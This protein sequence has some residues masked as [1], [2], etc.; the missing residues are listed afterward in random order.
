M[1]RI[2][3]A[4]HQ[5]DT[6]IE[7]ERFKGWDPHDALNSPLLKRATVGNRL[8]GIAW[9]QLLK[10]SPINPRPWLAVPK[11]HNPKGMGLFLASYLRKYETSG[12]PRHLAQARLFAD[13]LQQHVS[14]GYSGACWGYNFDWPNRGFFAPAG[15]PTVV[16]TAF[17]AQA[18]LDA[19]HVAH[20]LRALVRG[21]HRPDPDPLSVARSACEFLLNDLNHIRPRQDELCFS[22]TPLDR[23][24]VY[25]ANLLAAGLLAEVYAHTR[26]THLA[27]HSLAA[28]RHT[29]RRQRPDGSWTYGEGRAYGW[30]DNFHTGFV[31]IGLKRVAA[32]LQSSEFDHSIH[33]GYSFWKERLFLPDGTPK[34]YP[35]GVYPIDVHAVA[36]AIMT[37][38]AFADQ[39][40]GARDWAR[41]LAHWGIEHMQD[42]AG[43][44]HYQVHRHYRIRIPYMR[45]SQAWMQRALTEL[46][47]AR[48]TPP[49]ELSAI[50]ASSVREESGG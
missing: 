12:D 18:F 26:E 32:R 5:L 2:Q 39:D 49:T 20:E 40:S 46:V 14:P 8:L 24:W 37:F 44:F 25:N 45:W 23:R 22:Y 34:Y 19:T 42:P 17:I 43:Y 29:A 27:E 3:Q 35:S 6:W 7:R 41:R 33:H 30:V 47:W 11:G 31:L 48:D 16:N 36:Q 1:D 38:L 13:W 28:A 21:A 10:R 4:L 9:V 50:L 15:T